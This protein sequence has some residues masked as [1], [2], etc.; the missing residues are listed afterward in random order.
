M[1][2]ELQRAFHYHDD[3][4]AERLVGP[5]HLLLEHNCLHQPAQDSVP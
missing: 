4:G 3:E 5:R 1:R 2:H